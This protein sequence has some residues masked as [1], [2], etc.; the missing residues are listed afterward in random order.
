LA[1]PGSGCSPPPNAADVKMSP[2]RTY[3]TRLPSN[4]RDGCAEPGAA[5]IVPGNVVSSLAV[6]M[7]P[8]EVPRRYAISLSSDDH[9]RSEAFVR[10][11]GF[12][13]VPSGLIVQMFKPHV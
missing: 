8:G 4:E 3:A 5:P 1:N 12:F 11:E 7:S 10:N 13:P 9:D 2:P 6:K